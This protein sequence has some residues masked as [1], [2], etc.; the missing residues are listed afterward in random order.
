VTERLVVI[1]I[2]NT[3]TVLGLYDEG[4]LVRSW[5]VT[6]KAARTADEFRIVL[7]GLLA[8]QEIEPGD[9]DAVAV[10]SVVPPVTKNFVHAFEGKDVLE[11]SHRIAFGFEIAVPLPEQVGADRLVNAE[12]AIAK[13]GAPAIVV[14]SGTATTWC[15]IDGRRRYLGGAIA[16]GISISTDALFARA[17][18]LASVELKMPAKVIGNSTETALQS[19]IVNGYVALLDGMVARM[20]EEMDEKEIRVIGT[21]GWMELLGKA[22]KE[23][24]RVDPHLTLDGLYCLW[25]RAQGKPVEPGSL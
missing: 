9:V 22:S 17:S 24:Q 8:E 12:G 19:G 6:T 16:P 5:R 20:R 15:A 10:S 7:R 4:K 18:R 25:R 3:Q 1:D 2:G 14:D 23:I 11:V 21:G 13:Y